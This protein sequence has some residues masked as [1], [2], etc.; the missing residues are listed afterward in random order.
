MSNCRSCDARLSDN[1]EPFGLCAQCRRLLPA[2]VPELSAAA[3]STQ[4]ST[5]AERHS[6]VLT[7]ET[8]PDLDA[9]TDIPAKSDAVRRSSVTIGP[10]TTVD[11]YVALP[12]Q[13]ASGL[14]ATTNTA[15][16]SDT[17]TYDAGPPGGHSTARRAG[18]K[19]P[20]WRPSG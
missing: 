14:D 10:E 5:R 8:P 13:D 6:S 3:P 12:G 2:A 4:Y 20:R 1:D 16:K 9:T 18:R 15:A 17:A 19:N 11:N 7:Q